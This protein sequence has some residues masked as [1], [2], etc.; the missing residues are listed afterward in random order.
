MLKRELVEK[1]MQMAGGEYT[2]SQL[3]KMLKA[4]LERLYEEYSRKSV[5]AEKSAKADEENKSSDVQN[6]TMTAEERKAVEKIKS[7][8]FSIYENFVCAKK[9]RNRKVS[10]NQLRLIK[11]LELKYKVKFI[12]VEKATFGELSDRISNCFEAIKQGKVRKRTDNEI[13]AKLRSY[14]SEVAVTATSSDMSNSLEN[15]LKDKTFKT[16]FTEYLKRMF[17]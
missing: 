9:I 3:N 13:V 2:K 7:F 14:I 10:N 16:K 6:S 15:K 8:D 11:L 4:D 17:S 1:L 5:S 12:N